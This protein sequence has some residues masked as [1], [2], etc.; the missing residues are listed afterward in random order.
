MLTTQLLSAYSYPILIYEQWIICRKALNLIHYL[1]N[2]IPSDCG[3]VTNIGFRRSLM[4]LAL[5]VDPEVREAALRCLVELARYRGGDG[6][7]GILTKEE[8]VEL[9]RVVGERIEGIIKM[10]P[11]ELE[12]VKEERQL[13]DSLWNMFNEDQS[14]IRK[15]DL[16]VLPGE[17]DPAPDVASQHFQPPLRA[18]KD[19]SVK[20]DDS[21]KNELPLLLGLGP[22][23][24]NASL[25]APST[26]NG[27][28]GGPSTSN[29]A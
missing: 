23:A 8:V 11:S 16:L 20:V 13:L 15:N 29:A 9:N 24:N 6:T 7:K 3:T 18:S 2:E 19:A 1:L 10:P 26:N 4:H 22:S 5:S 25:G 14:P 28:L 21:E 27:S 12:V 17:D